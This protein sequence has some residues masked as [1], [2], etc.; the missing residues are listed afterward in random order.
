MPR[1]QDRFD[2]CIECKRAAVFEHKC[3]KHMTQMQV[4]KRLSNYNFKFQAERLRELAENPALK[5]LREEIGVLRLL[6][7]TVMNRCQTAEDLLVNQ[8]RIGDLISRIERLVNTCDRIE[9]SANMTLDKNVVIN[10]AQQLIDIT[11]KHITDPDVLH[12]I[13]TEFSGQTLKA[14]EGNNGE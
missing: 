1:Q 6:T 9:K 12:A 14:I 10:I 13:A 11:A 7:E 5:S 3:E 4:A 8:G 2:T